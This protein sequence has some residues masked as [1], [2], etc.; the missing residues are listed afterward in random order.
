[1]YINTDKETY[2]VGE[3]IIVTIVV[4][5]PAPREVPI[6]GTLT[7][8]GVTHILDTTVVVTPLDLVVEVVSVDASGIDFEPTANPLVWT[9]T[10]T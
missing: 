2:T 3:Q 1:M 10:A 8:D 7:I 9:G 4:E 6:S 5:E